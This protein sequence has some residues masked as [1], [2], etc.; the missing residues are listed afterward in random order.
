LDFTVVR[1]EKESGHAVKSLRIQI[2]S[3]EQ[4]LL[5]FPARSVHSCYFS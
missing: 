4:M 3:F 2:L 1:Y 5:Q